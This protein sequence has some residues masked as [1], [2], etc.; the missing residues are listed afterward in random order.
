MVGT[1]PRHNLRERALTRLVAKKGP[2]TRYDTS[3]ESVGG[4]SKNQGGRRSVEAAEQRDAQGS[5]RWTTLRRRRSPL[6]HNPEGMPASTANVSPLRS[7][8]G[9]RAEMIGSA[10]PGLTSCNRSPA[11]EFRTLRKKCRMSMQFVPL[12]FAQARASAPLRASSLQQGRGAAP[13]F[14]CKCMGAFVTAADA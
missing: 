9:D 3:C 1:A 7:I 14:T 11:A 13:L 10:A 5:R 2:R 12:R 4:D 8:L 6:P